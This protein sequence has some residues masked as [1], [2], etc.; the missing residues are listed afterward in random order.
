[1]P[2]QKQTVPLSPRIPR[3][4]RAQ[5]LLDCSQEVIRKHGPRIIRELE[6]REASADT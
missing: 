5:R 1:M 2:R 3:K 6:D 4:A